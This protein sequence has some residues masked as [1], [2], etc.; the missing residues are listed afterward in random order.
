MLRPN[1]IKKTQINPLCTDCPSLDVYDRGFLHTR[2]FLSYQ[3]ILN[4][5]ALYDIALAFGNYTVTV[6]PGHIY[7][8]KQCQYNRE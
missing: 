5:L 3:N 1:S 2:P 7:P 4:E 8:R 6:S